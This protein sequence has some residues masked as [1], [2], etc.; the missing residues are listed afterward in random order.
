MAT[1]SERRS[2]EVNPDEDRYP[3]LKKVL[4]R[5]G[6]EEDLP[7]GSIERVE[8][9]MFADGSATWR[10]WKPRSDD[11]VGGFYDKV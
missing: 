10:A 8:V 2:G 11:I 7:H 1:I 5:I 9:H 4:H 6:Q 3:S